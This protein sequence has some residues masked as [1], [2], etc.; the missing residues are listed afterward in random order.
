MSDKNGE[1]CWYALKV[2]YNRVFE[3][4]KQLSQEGVR[5]YIPLL[6]ED[7]VAGD[8]KIRKRKPA[9]SS[10]MFIRQSEHYLLELQDRMKASCPFM[11]YFDRE[12]K[13]PAVIPDR[14]MELFMQITSA[15]TSD[16]EYFSDEAID[17]RS[18]DK[19]RVT[20]GPFKGAEGYI[21][22]IRDV[23]WKKCPK[24]DL[25]A[26][27]NESCTVIV[28]KRDSGPAGLKPDALFRSEYGPLRK[29]TDYNIH[30]KS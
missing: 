23:S 13:K 12:T 21:K 26:S 5:S 25:R 24:T 19:V 16:L 17:Y 15:D 28:G 22:R 27:N 10:L 30:D 7:T 2:F 14:E 11:A 1:E 3:L 20:G 9:V 4:E 6:H 29:S 8:K 18:G